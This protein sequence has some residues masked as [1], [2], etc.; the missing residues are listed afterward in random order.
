MT[1]TYS[2]RFGLLD[3]F[4]TRQQVNA[5]VKAEP[6]RTITYPAHR[7]GFQIARD[8]LETMF[9][10]CSISGVVILGALYKTSDV[11]SSIFLG[12]IGFFATTAY[13]YGVNVMGRALPQTVNVI[14]DLR[15]AAIPALG[16]RQPS[17]A[18]VAAEVQQIESTA[19]KLPTRE[20]VWRVELQR[21]LL[22]GKLEGSYSN[23]RLAEDKRDERG[24]VIKQRYMTDTAWRLYSRVMTDDNRIMANYPTGLALAPGMDYGRAVFTIKH[25][26][27]TL[28]VKPE[29]PPTVQIG[30][31]GEAGGRVGAR[32]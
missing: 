9:F 11:V 5:E 16:K 23:Q 26:T 21:F 2:K 13:V 18:E 29:F 10:A 1:T 3:I 19:P 25:E 30:G 28:P 8:D 6:I 7:P 32:V 12:G 27:L 15:V 31:R 20:D 24:R 4:R 17:T 22:S 14:N